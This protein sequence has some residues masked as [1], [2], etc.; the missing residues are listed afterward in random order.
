MMTTLAEKGENFSQNLS[1]H[2]GVIW[3]ETRVGHYDFPTNLASNLPWASPVLLAGSPLAGIPWNATFTDHCLYPGTANYNG[4]YSGVINNSSAT[5]DLA[6]VNENGFTVNIDF[7]RQTHLRIT[8]PGFQTSE[9]QPLETTEPLPRQQINPVVPPRDIDN[10]A[11]TIIAGAGKTASANL[12]LQNDGRK[13]SKLDL[14][15]YSLAQ[16]SFDATAHLTPTRLTPAS[17]PVAQT[18]SKPADSP[19]LAALYTPKTFS[20]VSVKQ[21]ATATGI[22]TVSATCPAKVDRELTFNE[23]LELV[24]TTGRI[25]EN[26]TPSVVT[27][28]VNEKHHLTIPIRLLCVAPRMSDTIPA[29]LTL[30]GNAYGSVASGAI[31]FDNIGGPD[32][33]GSLVGLFNSTRQIQGTKTYGDL[34]RDNTKLTFSYISSPTGLTVTPNPNQTIIPAYERGINNGQQLGFSYA[35]TK[36]GTQNFT[37][38]ISSND[39]SNAPSLLTKIVNVTVLCHASKISSL[40]GPTSAIRVLFNTSVYI[41][42]SFSNLGDAPLDYTSRYA[43]GSLVPGGSVTLQA[44]V[45]CGWIPGDHLET[46]AVNAS[47]DPDTSQVSLV[48]TVHCYGDITV[49]DF[50]IIEENMWD[51]LP[52]Q[53]YQNGVPIN[54]CNQT[55]GKDIIMRFPS[56][57]TLSDVEI[58]ISYDQNKFSNGES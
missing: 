34:I 33:Q 32:P 45:S 30:N 43:S 8:E 12:T 11:L 29:S 13:A 21:T 2:K 57:N 51:S 26:G 20:L 17:V 38:T 50:D 46:I 55:V 53:A 15:V 24:Y 22:L 52:G 5:S 18:L 3:S 49:Y 14:T 37:L 54:A 48:I 10:Q 25:D 31:N 23:S 39:P 40:S 16:T 47:N 36:R 41:G 19:W 6:D 35:C 56:L 27:D 28:D 1:Y 44:Q 7:D 9:P 42:I 4:L 58:G